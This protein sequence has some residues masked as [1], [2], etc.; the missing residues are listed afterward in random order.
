M[1]ITSTTI[2]LKGKSPLVVLGLSEYE[3]LMDYIEDMEDRLLI[4]KRV[5]EENIPWGETQKKIARKFM[6]K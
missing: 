1:T 6:A 4:R 5:H 2:K 3:K